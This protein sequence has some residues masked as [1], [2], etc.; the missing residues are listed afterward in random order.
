MPSTPEADKPLT[1][2]QIAAQKKRKTAEVPITV[3]PDATPPVVAVFRL[4]P[5]GRPQWE[6][7]V[8]DH[9][10]TD[11]QQ[12]AHRDSQEEQGVP[13]ALRG[14]LRWDE[15]MFP[16]ALLAASCAEPELSVEQAASIWHDDGEKWSA[17]ECEVLFQTALE[18]NDPQFERQQRLFASVGKGSTPTGG[19]ET[20]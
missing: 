20:K 9:P 16:P 13:L 10:A 19:S 8:L 11:V 6:H 14:V 12:K 5:I 15:D 3:D 4:R 7:L 17:G 18:L 1:F 2:E